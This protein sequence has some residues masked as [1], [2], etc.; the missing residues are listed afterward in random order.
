MI[1]VIPSQLRERVVHIP[2]EGHQGLVKSKALIQQKVW[3]PQIDEHTK[4]VVKNWMECQVTTNERTAANVRARVVAMARGQHRLLRSCRKLH[5][6][7]DRRL[8]P[9]PSNRAAN[10]NIG[11]TPARQNILHLWNSQYCSLRQW[12][13]VQQ[14]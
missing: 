6:S 7:R 3:F 8:L 2:H 10:L 14:R 1:L 4:Q 9:I 11:E 5:F 12:T 13:T